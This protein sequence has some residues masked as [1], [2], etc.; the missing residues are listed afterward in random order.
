MW[1]VMKGDKGMSFVWR[2]GS[3]GDSRLSHHTQNSPGHCWG[4]MTTSVSKY[5]G[6]FHISK[7]FANLLLDMVLEDVTELYGVTSPWIISPTNILIV[8]IL[9]PS[10]SSQRFCWTETISA[11]YSTSIPKFDFFEELTLLSSWYPE[12]KGRLVAHEV[13]TLLCCLWIFMGKKHAGDDWTTS[14]RENIMP[15]NSI[16]VKIFRVSC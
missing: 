7:D 12:E 14:S 3:N 13:M 10:T 16:C 5:T 4:S 9:V 11:W 8:T 1:V 2:S 15:I 6:L